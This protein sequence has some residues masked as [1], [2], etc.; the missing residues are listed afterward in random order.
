MHENKWLENR[1]AYNTIYADLKQ[2]GALDLVIVQLGTND[3]KSEYND[4]VTDITNNLDILL[5]II[6]RETNSNIMVISPAI[7][8]EDNKITQKYYIGAQE[9]SEQ[10]DSQ[11]EKLCAKKGYLFISGKDLETG[12]DGEH[13]TKKAHKQL[14]QRVL[15]KV[16]EMICEREL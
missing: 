7:I 3:C 9:K 2:Y 16:N 4:S 11:F 10:L 8:V 15:S 13:L 1:N 5:K 12:E 14:G 6:T